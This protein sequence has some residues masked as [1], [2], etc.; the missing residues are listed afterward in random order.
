MK[1]I[2]LSVFICF[3]AIVGV[4][5]SILNEATNQLYLN[6]E[7]EAMTE[8]ATLSARSLQYIDKIMNVWKQAIQK[9]KNTKTIGEIKEIKA[10]VNDEL[11]DLEDMYI[12][13]SKEISHFFFVN[14]DHE[15]T[16]KFNREKINFEREIEY[17]EI[18]VGAK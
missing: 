1:S 4:K 9:L 8:Q 11:E 13:E 5:A 2:F 18:R 15:I 17:A 12:K 7:L 6:N 10:R 16:K 14:K 3:I